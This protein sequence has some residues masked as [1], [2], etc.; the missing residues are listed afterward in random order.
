MNTASI[1]IKTEPDIK[2]QAQQ[3]ADAV[4]VSLTDLINSYLKQLVKHKTAFMKD[5]EYPTKY[6]LK[7]IALAKKERKEGK[8]STVFDN[9]EDA[10]K[11][12]NS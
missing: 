7:T 3:V 2:E 5:T 6:L 12:L 11:W 8:T 10:T 9:P 4:G 1:S